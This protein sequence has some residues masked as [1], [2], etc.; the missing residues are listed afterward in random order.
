MGLCA[1]YENQG[2]NSIAMGQNA[3]YQDQHNNTI[4]LNAQTTQL[5]SNSAT[6]FYVAPISN[7]PNPTGVTGVLYYNE[8]TKEIKYNTSK[9]FVI[10]HPLDND[11]YL[12][13]S[14]LEGPEAGVYYRGKG[15][16]TNN[17]YVTITLPKYVSKLAFDLSVQT[18]HIYNGK[19][20]NLSSTEVENN[21]FKV[22]GENCKFWWTV[23]GSRSNIEIEPY[24]NLVNIKGDGPYKWI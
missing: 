4:I 21:E 3:G 9:T 11:K 16:I 1:G 22:Y 24:K 8:T 6:G 10:D 23:F 19:I 2:S 15:E 13:H 5:N 7:I 12:V 17:E 18:N 14:C 20:V